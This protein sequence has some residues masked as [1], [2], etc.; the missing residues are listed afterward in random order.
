[1]VKGQEEKIGLKDQMGV[2]LLTLPLIVLYARYVVLWYSAF[3]SGGL[4]VNVQIIV[5]YTLSNQRVI[6]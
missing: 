1:M 6:L 3:M 5:F 4:G 2:H